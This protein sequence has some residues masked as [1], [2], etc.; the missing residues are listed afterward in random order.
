[1]GLL[2]KRR[3]GEVIMIGDDIRVTV[4]R[5]DGFQILIDIEAPKDIPVHRKEVYDRIKAE[6]ELK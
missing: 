3:P 4:E 6:G 2:L 1:M 5:V